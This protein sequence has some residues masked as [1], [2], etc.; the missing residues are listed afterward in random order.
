[1]GDAE[2]KKG[3]AFRALFRWNID[4]E[5]LES[6]LI[7]YHDLSWT[8]CYRKMIVAY[9]LA[10]GTIG[11]LYLGLWKQDSDQAI[12]Q[13]LVL[14]LFGGLGFYA[15]KGGRKIVWAVGALG[16]LLKA[17]DIILMVAH[18]DLPSIASFLLL[19][20]LVM[21]SHRANQ[22]EIERIKRGMA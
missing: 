18:D 21:F 11:F 20:M 2:S 22:I 13:A 15:W 6:N 16:I 5:D 10:T 8:H 19:W 12:G 17:G 9:L 1:M 7:G 3:E 4:S 14:F